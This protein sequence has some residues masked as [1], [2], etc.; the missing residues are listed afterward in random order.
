MKS[1]VSRR[2]AGRVIPYKA[3]RACRLVAG[4]R[5]G[6]SGSTARAARSDNDMS[7]ETR[8]N[9]F[10]LGRCTPMTR[11]DEHECASEYARTRSPLL[12]QR[13]ITANMRLV[14]K[15]AYSYR[16]PNCEMSDLV[17]EGNFGLIQAVLRYDPH[18]GV[19]LSTYAA[20][21]IRA[22][23]LKFTLDNWR[24]VK[25][26]TTEPQ[27][28]MFFSLQREKAALE[29]NG[30]EADAAHLAAAMSLKE[31]DVAVMLERFASSEVSLDAPR[32]AYGEKGETL[33]DR[34]GD[35]PARR[36][37]ERLEASDLSRT[38]LSELK[39]IEDTLA[40]R[41]LTIFRRRIMCEDPATLQDIAVDFGVTRERAR[42][43]EAEL[44]GRIQENLKKVMGD[45]LE[46]LGARA[47]P[48][49]ATPRSAR[50]GRAPEAVVWSR[51]NPGRSPQLMAA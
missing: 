49:A 26:G 25:A 8:R 1:E 37:D 34:I 35:A 43:I 22:S 10:Q 11:E 31:K 13:L 6:Y 42:Q 17:Q 14:V 30:V 33:A 21:W 3:P 48:Y 18:R 29:K 4:A 32:S 16:R 2:I 5:N 39:A 38:L 7:F 27:R 15:L 44:K 28:R 23:I 9:Q 20:W 51:P 19:R 40:G 24:L 45:A 46:G 41:D 47:R 12:A 50:P 36:P